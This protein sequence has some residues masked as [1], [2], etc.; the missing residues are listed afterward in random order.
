MG[1]LQRGKRD[2]T[3]P[4]NESYQEQYKDVGRRQEAGESCPVK[5]KP[6]VSKHGNW[7]DKR[8]GL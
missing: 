2:G 6:T 8:S 4:F 1:K 3:G 5:K 7:H